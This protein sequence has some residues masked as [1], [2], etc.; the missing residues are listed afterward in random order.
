MLSAG[1]RRPAGTTAPA[2]AIRSAELRP[3]SGSSSMRS[4]S[5]TPPMRGLRVSTSG[6]DASTDT[7]S[8]SSPSCSVTGITGLLLTCSTMP[9]WTYVRKPGERHLQPIRSDRQVRQRERARGVGDD[10]AAEAGVGLD[11]GDGGARQHAAAGVGD[12]AVDLRGGLGP[13][14]RGHEKN[15]DSAEQ[16][17][18]YAIH[19]ASSR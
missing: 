3:L 8:A 18:Q 4:F 14:L 11:G 13:R 5:M 7:V 6:A 19:S 12:G 2:I 1:R 15:Q 16:G 17:S 9:V 10:L